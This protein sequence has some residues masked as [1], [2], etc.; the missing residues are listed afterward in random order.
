MITLDVKLREQTF[1]ALCKL[2]AARNMTVSEMVEG[3]LFAL[4]WQ[5]PATFFQSEVCRMHG[6]GLTVAW[7]ACQLNVPNNRVQVEMRK[8]GLSANRPITVDSAYHRKA[9]Q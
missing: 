2:A 6:E 9:N 3:T 8:Q 7:I 5:E 1:T 4:C